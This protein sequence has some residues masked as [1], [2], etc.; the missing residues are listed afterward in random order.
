MKIFSFADVG[1]REAF[2]FFVQRATVEAGTFAMHG[3]H[4]SE[5]VVVLSGSGRHVTESETYRIGRGDVFVLNGPTRHA[6]ED[7]NR[8]KVCNIMYDPERFVRPHED[9]NAAPGYQALFVLEP[10]HRETYGFRGRLQLGAGELV[11]VVSL[12]DALEHEQE[13]CLQGFQSLLAAY[14]MQ[15]VVLLSRY[16]SA[17]PER[18]TRAMLRLADTLAYLEENYHRPLD[19]SDLADRANLSRNQFLR[20]FKK[21]FGTTPVTYLASRRI[22][23][24]QRLLEDTALS[25]SQIAFDTGFSDSNYFS[26]RF[27][28]LTGTSPRAY[29]TS[30]QR[31]LPPVQERSVQK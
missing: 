5:L 4:F 15:L 12:L 24:A 19:L 16:Y 9:L 30:L 3:H 14:F 17:S 31:D 27:Y 13:A 11:R 1:H 6:F 26:R 7:T 8:L 29:R 21:A 25:I 22:Q 20:V 18:P 28:Q 2:P 10:L 23:E